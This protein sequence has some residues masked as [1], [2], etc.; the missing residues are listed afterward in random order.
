MMNHKENAIV[1]V[2]LA[3]GTPSVFFFPPNETLHFGLE[4]TKNF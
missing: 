2:A 4:S 1:S 3:A